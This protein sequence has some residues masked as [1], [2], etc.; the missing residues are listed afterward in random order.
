MYAVAGET[1]ARC[2]TVRIV[3]ASC[4]TVRSSSRR[5]GEQLLDGLRLARVEPLPRHAGHLTGHVSSLRLASRIRPQEVAWVVRHEKP[6]YGDRAFRGGLP[7]V[8]ATGQNGRVL[9]ADVVAASQAV[10]A[11]RSR[12]AK[13]AALAELL[14]QAAPDEVETVTSYLAGSAAPAAHRPG[15]ARPVRRCRSRPTPPR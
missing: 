4:P 9:L 14:A 15:L 1:P 13:V 11:T 5:R 6:S 2:A 12:K 8:G 10:A 3:S 7:P